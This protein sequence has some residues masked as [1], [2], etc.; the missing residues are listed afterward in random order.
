MQ[1]VLQS[2]E[3]YVAAVLAPLGPTISPT[4][5]SETRRAFY[6][7]FCSMLVACERLGEPDITEARGI[8]YLEA[9]KQ[10]VAKFY[11]DVKANR[12]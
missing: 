4:Q 6:A 10:E 2:W 3:S 11:D 12:A 1:T 8:G 7:G 5:Y 9:R